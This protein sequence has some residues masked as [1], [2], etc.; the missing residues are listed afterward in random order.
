[1]LWQ[2][3][4]LNYWKIKGTSNQVNKSLPINRSKIRKLT[5]YKNG[6]SVLKP[7]K[8]FNKHYEQIFCLKLV[9]KI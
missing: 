9:S 8:N 4:A 7:A 5:K 3:D 2:Y 6:L 1:M